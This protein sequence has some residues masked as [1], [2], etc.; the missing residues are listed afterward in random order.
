MKCVRDSSYKIVTRGE[1]IPCATEHDIFEVLG[2]AYR[3]PWE[4]PLFDRKSMILRPIAEAI[5]GKNN[6]T[7][8]RGEAGAR[9]SES[10]GGSGEVTGSQLL[11]V[12]KDTAEQEEQQS[13]LGKRCNSMER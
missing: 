2:L 6:N 4:R 13:V 9:R 10:K 8:F 12:D 5:K 1:L 7:A 3:E 11:N